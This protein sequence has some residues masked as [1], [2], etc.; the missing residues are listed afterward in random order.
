MTGLKRTP[1][2]RGAR[3]PRRQDGGLRRLGD[4]AHV[5]HGS[6]RRAPRHPPHA[7]GCST[8]P[9]WAGSSSRGPGALRFLQRSSATTRPPSRWARRS[10]P[11]SPPRP[12]ARS[13][14]PTS[15][16]S[17]P[18]STC[19]WSTPPTAGRTGPTCRSGWRVRRDVPPLREPGAT[20]AVFPVT[21]EDRTADLAM[22]SLQGPLSR[23]I[24]AA[25]SRRARSPSPGATSSRSSDRPGPRPPRPAPATPANRWASSC[26]SPPST[27]QPSGIFSSKKALFP[28]AWARGTPC[29]WKP[30]CPSTATS[31]A[32]TRRG[33][34][35]RS[36]P[37][38]WP[39][40]R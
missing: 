13:T 22:L 12:A 15:T 35:S 9:T 11:S 18:T 29:A 2:Y 33:T 25:C 36:S 19:W 26:S 4:A 20:R 10:T 14:T 7:P 34:R 38:P 5:S 8:S 23:E 24:V 21:L 40:S 1:L 17:S 16:A 3:R 27:P 28:V 6:G 32:P 31:W 30:A 37:L 39:R